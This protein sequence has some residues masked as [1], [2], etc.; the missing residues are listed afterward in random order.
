ML[1]EWDAQEVT[2]DSGLEVEESPKAGFTCHQMGE[3]EHHSVEGG[4]EEP[5]KAGNQKEGREEG[6]EREE[7]KE[8]EERL[9]NGNCDSQRGRG[10]RGVPGNG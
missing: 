7:E 10:A 3:A 4:T 8:R 1:A 6:R 2:P 5:P 9:R